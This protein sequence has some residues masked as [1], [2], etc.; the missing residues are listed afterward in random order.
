MSRESSSEIKRKLLKNLFKDKTIQGR[1]HYSLSFIQKQL[2]IIYLLDPISSVY[3][4]YI[5]CHKLYV[6][7]AKKIAENGFHVLG[8]YRCC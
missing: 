5:R 8:G 3:N 4:E 6:T 2:S 7:L 1:R